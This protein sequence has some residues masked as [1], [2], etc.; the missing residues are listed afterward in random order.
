MKRMRTEYCRKSLVTYHVWDS[1][2]DRVCMA[3]IRA[4]HRAFLHMYLEMKRRYKMCC[5]RNQGGIAYL[6][7]NM[8]Q[9]FQE[10]IV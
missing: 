10:I 3:T 4:Y 8:M 7:E 5:I 6:E 2:R 1:I 9:G